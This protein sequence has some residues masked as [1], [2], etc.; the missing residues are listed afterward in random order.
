[1][2]PDA[3]ADRPKLTV[4]DLVTV[5]TVGEFDVAPDGSQIAF[6]WNRAGISQINAVSATGGA[7][8]PITTGPEAKVSPRWSPDGRFIAYLQDVGGDENFDVYLHVAT[9]RGV[10]AINLTRDPEHA[11]RDVH[12]SPDSRRLVAVSNLSGN[13]EVTRIEPERGGA[14][15]LTAEDGPVVG[16]RWSPDNRWIAY[17][18]RQA[19]GEQRFAVK[20]VAPDG[21]RVRTLGD[22]GGEAGRAALRWSPDGRYVAFLSDERSEY[23][24]LAVV[25][26][27][28]G[29]VRWLT[30]D[31]WDKATPEW[32]PDGS[33]LAYVINQ[34]GE[35]LCRVLDLATG[36]ELPVMLAA[37]VTHSPQWS[38]DGGR[39]FVVHAGPRSPND[40]WAVGLADAATQRLTNGLRADIDPEELVEPERIA[41]PTFDGRGVPALLYQP[42]ASA[43]QAHP[44][45]VVLVHGGPADQFMNGWD[46]MTQI[47]VTRG[48]VVLAPN[49]RGSTGYGKTYR[50]LTVEDWG[51]GDLQDVMA[52]ARYLVEQDLADPE[53]IGITGGSYGGYLTMMA[54]TKAPKLWAAGVSSMG[55]TSLEGLWQAARVGDVRSYLESQLGGGPEDRPELYE[56]RSPLQ[57]AERIQAP[58]LMLHGAADPR[59]PVSDAEQMRDVLAARGI[60]HELHVYPEEGHGFRAT[61]TRIDATERTLAFFERHLKASSPA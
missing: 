47:L 24:Q 58:V 36:R 18:V 10:S 13:F 53:R 6:A 19:D 56:E 21:M 9:Q 57:S 7:P 20:L 2:E 49:V 34:A 43:S 29:R 61:E 59:V 17:A 15:H 39:L 55:I 14:E 31:T 28:S 27:E 32:S 45:A 33:R 5:P 41:Y 37:G 42:P 8:Q 3:H 1:M 60:P 44:P 48:Y 52:G 25:D 35:M 26:V 46:P 38:P 22:F 16:P 40:L 30:Q 51:G 12:W 4:Q 23:A 50:D 11:Y 54:L